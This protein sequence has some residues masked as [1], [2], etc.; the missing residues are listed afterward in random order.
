MRSASDTLERLEGKVVKIIFSAKDSDYTIFVVRDKKTGKH[1][2]VV[3]GAP[4]LKAGQKVSVLGH[5]SV[6]KTYGRQF[7][8]KGFETNE[9]AAYSG[10]G[11][12]GYLASGIVKGIGPQ[13][14][15]RLVQAF[16]AD[17]FKVVE[18]TPERLREVEGIGEEKIKAIVTALAKQKTGRSAVLFLYEHGVKGAAAKRILKAYGKKAVSKIVENPYRLAKEVDGFGFVSADTVALSLGFDP[19]S[20]KR[21]SAA[22]DYVL[23]TAAV[24]DGDCRLATSVLVRRVTDLTEASRSVIESEIGQGAERNDLIVEDGFVY[25]RSLYL[26]EERTA[27]NVARLCEPALSLPWPAGDPDEVIPQAEESLSIRLSASQRKA[28]EAAISSKFLVITGGPGVGKTTVLRVILSILEKS[29]IN[30]ALCAPTGRAAKRMKESCRREAKTIHRLLEVNP[31]TKQFARN[32][33]NPLDCDL[34]VVDEFSMVDIFLADA[35][36]S[37]VPTSAA[38]LIVGDV[39]Q[40]PSVGPGA[41]L[42]DL[43]ISRTVPVVRMNEVFR[44]AA[45]S[46]I[47]RVAHRI[48]DGIFPVIAD[49]LGDSDCCFIEKATP[50]EIADE[51]VRMTTEVLP[52]ALG[53]D[54]KRDIQILCPM[55]KGEI[56]TLELNRRLQVKLNPVGHEQPII[57]RFGTRYAVGD[58]VMQIENDYEKQLFNGDIG[59]VTEVDPRNQSLAADFDGRSVNFKYDELGELMLCYAATVH[60]S[61]GSEYP[62]VVMPVATQHYV[63]LQRN[64]FYTGVTRGKKQVVLIGQKKALSI[65]VLG[66]QSNGRETGLAEKLEAAVRKEGAESNTHVTP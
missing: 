37:A 5:W 20:P 40:L 47:V 48:N 52:A 38:V 53:T 1:E 64:L 61:Q 31:K 15:K 27:E 18:K 16:G 28:V 11:I 29:G 45:E 59:F 2:T 36:F 41:V 50:E 17:F 66:R 26:A 21:V 34:I 65:A 9:E 63:M 62:V 6:H 46:A 25:R 10:R 58:K 14:A 19:Q 33:H 44:Q 4:E 42:A 56:G 3:G 49:K 32:A 60:K 51:V 23:E 54:P 39:D 55:K 7:A 30:I 22:I 43:L 24:R 8:A 12:E 57:E 13:L 35:L